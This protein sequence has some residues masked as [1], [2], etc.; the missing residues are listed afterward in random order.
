MGVDHAACL[1]SR[2]Y[3]RCQAYLPAADSGL[4][5]VQRPGVSVQAA[6]RVLCMAK[7]AAGASGAPGATGL[8]PGAAVRVAAADQELALLEVQRAVQPDAARRLPPEELLHAALAAAERGA[9]DA[10]V[11][12]VQVFAAASGEFAQQHAHA[13]VPAWRHATAASDWKQ[14][15]QQRGSCADA[16]FDALLASQPLSRAAALL[17]GRGGDAATALS[18]E[19]VLGHVLSQV[20]ATPVEARQCARAAFLIGAAR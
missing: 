6:H 17:Y 18:Q 3:C 12:A 2:R 16:E 4:S 10:G 8:A 1:P 15:A 11:H 20:P 19:E 14:L 9:A 5:Y 7:L 13:L